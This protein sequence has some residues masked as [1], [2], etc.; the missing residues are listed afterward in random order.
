LSVTRYPL[1][2]EA[3]ENQGRANGVVVDPVCP[4]EDASPG[5]ECWEVSN[6]VAVVHDEGKL[7]RT[8]VAEDWLESRVSRKISSSLRKFPPSVVESFRLGFRRPNKDEEMVSSAL[9]VIC[10]LLVAR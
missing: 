5:F 1:G 10:W 6:D 3:E 2:L 7:I 4:P 8:E 9:G